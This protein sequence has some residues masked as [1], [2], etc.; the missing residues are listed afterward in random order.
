[1]NK[2]P[3]N[4]Q[5]DNN[6]ENSDN[7]SNGSSTRT[8]RYGSISPITTPANITNNQLLTSMNEFPPSPMEFRNE[9]NNDTAN[10]NSYSRSNL[11]FTE[12]I[13]N[14]NTP[15]DWRIS[16]EGDQRSNTP[17]MR[18]DLTNSN[19]TLQAQ[20][21]RMSLIRDTSSNTPAL[22]NTFRM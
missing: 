21:R 5:T 22:T 10:G 3:T 1:M 17:A 16:S 12:N 8:P 9:N 15:S 18:E 7:Q 2:L 19:N 13:N 14:I 4:M 20:D 6:S 11:Y